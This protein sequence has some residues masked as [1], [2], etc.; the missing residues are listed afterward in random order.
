M[1]PW[2]LSTTHSL[3]RGKGSKTIRRELWIQLSS[4]SINL[5]KV[6]LWRIFQ[7]FHKLSEQ[8]IPLRV[9]LKPFITF[10]AVSVTCSMF[11]NDFSCLRCEVERSLK[12]KAQRNR[13]YQETAAWGR[14]GCCCWTP[15]LCLF[16]CRS[17]LVWHEVQRRIPLIVSLNEALWKPR[18]FKMY[19]PRLQTDLMDSWLGI[20]CQQKY[21]SFD[22]KMHRSHAHKRSSF[23]ALEIFFISSFS[24]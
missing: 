18:C 24:S 19:G 8:K 9:C 4:L 15:T 3:F 21:W 14:R 10:F 17:L 6:R 2:H 23:K 5:I 20:C 1:L 11:C 7:L 22:A 16:S 13:V 12:R